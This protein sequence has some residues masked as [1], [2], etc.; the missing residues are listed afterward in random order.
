MCGTVNPCVLRPWLF[1]D[2]PSPY[3][4]T[5]ALWAATAGSAPRAHRVGVPTHD[6]GSSITPLRLLAPSRAAPRVPYGALPT[7]PRHPLSPPNLFL[8]VPQRCSTV[9]G[10]GVAPQTS[11]GYIVVVMCCFLGTPGFPQGLCSP[12]G[13]KLCLIRFFRRVPSQD[14]STG[15]RAGGVGQLPHAPTSFCI[16]VVVCADA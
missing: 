11:L 13:C 16:C 10:R 3:L 5:P 7:K 4:H 12:A 8:S 14:G 1:V 2:T 6:P 15:K 9:C